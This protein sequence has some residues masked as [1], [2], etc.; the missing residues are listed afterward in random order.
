G[1]RG[2]SAVPRY[3]AHSCGASFLRPDRPSHAQV[4]S[5][6]SFESMGDTWKVASSLAVA[7][8]TFPDSSRFN[9]TCVTFTL[10]CTRTSSCLLP[11]SGFHIA[12]CNFDPVVTM[13]LSSG[14]NWAVAMSVSPSSGSSLASSKTPP[15]HS[16][17]TL[18]LPG[19]ARG[20]ASRLGHPST[21]Y[22][23]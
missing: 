23:L 14:V 10:K 5:F 17:S 16:G 18:P 1:G 20:A 13:L 21:T 19:A 15:S 6:K 22:T 9:A 7:S 12:T 4:W 11:V 3:F 2:Q 8:Q